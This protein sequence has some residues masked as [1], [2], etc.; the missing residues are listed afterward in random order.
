MEQKIPGE[1]YIIRAQKIISLLLVITILLRLV[2]CKI[3]TQW[4][5]TTKLAAYSLGNMVFEVS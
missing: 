5:Q 3:F 2:L 1:A 4:T